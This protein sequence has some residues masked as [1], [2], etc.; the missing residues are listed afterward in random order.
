[1][2][3]EILQDSFFLFL[4]KYR[5]AIFTKPVLTEHRINEIRSIIKEHPEMGRSQLSRQICT[6]WEWQSPTGQL[7]D[8]AAREMLRSLDKSGAIKLPAVKYN[9]GVASKKTSIKWLIHDNKPIECNLSELLPL[10]VDIVTGVALAEFK[11]YID[12]FH[13]LHFD[14]TIG[15]NMKYMIY[16]RNGTPLACML[17]GSASWSCA[18][19]DKYIG[20]D[21]EHRAKN[22]M[23]MTSNS[24]FLILPWV[25]VFNL[26]SHILSIISKRISNDWE[27]KYG[28][29]L[30]AL[31]TYVERGRFLGTC[32]KSANWIY[33]GKTS[34][35]G[36]DGGHHNAIL[37]EKDIYLFPLCKSFR[38]V[39]GGALCKKE[40]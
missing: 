15:E 8:I 2:N 13:Y 23:F 10:S 32:Y 6:L 26:A 21:K 4:Y 12:Q 36:R 25:K 38:E 39:L 17:F 40:D 3:S 28:H 18:D 37:P 30:Y 1:M 19:R 34:G 20:W 29:S 22:L 16:S 24:R 27:M 14:R 5:M 9:Y 31:E 11:S 7:K 33:V 35:R